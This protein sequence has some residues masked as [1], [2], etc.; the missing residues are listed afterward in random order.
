MLLKFKAD[1]L[2]NV[3]AAEADKLCEN[4]IQLAKSCDSAKHANTFEL[5]LCLQVTKREQR[6]FEALGATVEDIA[7]HAD[8]PT[9]FAC[10]HR[11]R[12]ASN[13]AINKY[14]GDKEEVF[15]DTVE[16]SLTALEEKLKAYVVIALANADMKLQREA[17]TLATL[18]SLD[19][20]TW[21]LVWNVEAAS[22]DALIESCGSNILRV[23]AKAMKDA[24]A[25]FRQVT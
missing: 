1:A 4:F 14:K 9:A 25:T 23:E 6:N 2:A 24:I 20:S 8:G 22:Y 5:Q 15:K 16:A 3:E 10:V 13:A 19:Q 12:L 18:C 17:A 11:A 7:A 21:E